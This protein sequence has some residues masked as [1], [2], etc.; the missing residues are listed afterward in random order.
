M[1]L[2]NKY[3]ICVAK[4]NEYFSKENHKNR[5]LVI[6]GMNAYA[7]ILIA[8]FHDR[9][10]PIGA[11][12]DNDSSKQGYIYCGEK[13]RKPE[14]VMCALP[15]N[16]IIIVSSKAYKDSITKDIIGYQEKYAD[17]IWYAD[18]HEELD[19]PSKLTDKSGL[20][21]AKLQ[22]IQ[23]EN[24]NMLAWLVDVCRENGLRCFVNY[25]TL[26][27]AV[28]HNGFIPWDDDVDVCLPISDYVKLHKILEKQD[29]YGFESMLAEKSECLSMSTIAKIKSKKIIV[30]DTNFPVTYEDFLAIDIWAMGGYPDNEEESQEY[31]RELRMLADEWKETAVIPFGTEYFKEDAYRKL[32]HK[33]LCTMSRYDYE[34]S[35]YVG[36][37]YCGFLGHI[38]HDV[39][40]RGLG[41]YNYE[42]TVTAMFEGKEIEVPQ[43]YDEILRSKYG[44]WTIPPE[45]ADK[46]IHSFS[47][48]AYI[49]D[50]SYFEVNG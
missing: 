11:V 20:R 27:G 43:G 17:Q 14:E 1:F 40:R 15:E 6:F 39:L 3:S 44:D 36:E 32:A 8:Y 45:D 22:D 7:K 21:K 48:A 26:L 29:Q 47:S 31:Y 16:A 49:I 30:E 18:L 46:R 50:D 34:T 37:V 33:L 41:K 2:D 38:R 28:R 12:I 19:I 4:L 13:I 25:G 35:H 42:K 23:K 10:I 24:F 9:G 5:Y